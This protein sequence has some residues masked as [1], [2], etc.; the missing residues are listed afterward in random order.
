MGDPG[1]REKGSEG[2][3]AAASG[4]SQ[5][6]EHTQ[7]L[8]NE[9]LKVNGVTPVIGASPFVHHG[10]APGNAVEAFVSSA[11]ASLVAPVEAAG[12]LLDRAAGTHTAEAL[13]KVAGT[14]GQADFGSL[15]WAASQLGT[16]AG[17]T[18]W[19]FGL[20]RGISGSVRSLAGVEELSVAQRIG[21]SAASGF[22]YGTGL[23]PTGSG[24]NDWI[25]HRLENGVVSALSFTALTGSSE[26]LGTRGITNKAVSGFLAGAP[27][28][29]V[30]T[31]AR[32]LWNDGKF[33]FDQELGQS[34]ATYAFL[35]GALGALP[36]FG[37]SEPKSE[38]KSGPTQSNPNDANAT[39]PRS[40]AKATP[41]IT[42]PPDM[43]RSPDITRPPDNTMQPNATAQ[44]TDANAQRTEPTAQRLEATAPRTDAT[45]PRTEAAAQSESPA[46]VKKS[47]DDQLVKA[48]EKV[49][50]TGYFVAEES[51]Q[52]IRDGLT[53]N[54]APVPL[55]WSAPAEMHVTEEFAVK[56]GAGNA[57]AK[58]PASGQNIRVI[59]YALDNTGVESLVVSVDG[60]TQRSDGKYYHLT[61]SL[62]EGR[63][64]NESMSVVEKAMAVEKARAEG[65]LAEI[66]PEV[67]QRYSY[68][69][70]SP[71]EQ[72]NLSVDARF[73]ESATTPKAEKTKTAK[74]EPSFDSLT[75]RLQVLSALKATPADYLSQTIQTRTPEHRAGSYF[76]MTPQQ[77]KQ[78][79]F[80]AKWEPYNPLDAEGHPLISGGARGYR[81]TIPGGRLGMV[82]VEQLP[83]GANL[84]LIDPKG[85]GKWSLSTI[86]TAE[87]KTDTATMIVGP[88]EAGKHSLW[89]FHPGE[90]VRT[91]L[92]DSSTLQNALGNSGIKTEGL[93]E[94]GM[95]RRIAITAEQLNQIN[96]ALPDK[97]KFGL[98][99]IESA[100]NL[101]KP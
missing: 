15:T 26:F 33:K 59:G 58:A 10:P 3:A 45:V 78:E 7:L 65:R 92:L 66:P 38:A 93:P 87:P 83:A 62:A 82:P 32:S 9:T 75:P 56:E 89:T 79:L 95:G 64:A 70:L 48:K 19:L 55:R 73:K 47:G 28:G 57:W 23:T 74:P 68:T 91:S 84:Y 98:A 13:A 21:V 20:H 35:G 72:F 6:Q 69:A 63:R 88:D 76:D 51:G 24:D 71:A 49:G 80:S 37:K 17:M 44:R 42:R 4:A 86:G 29:F 60:Q 8:L 100:D 40:D 30:D 67:A 1:K 22:V 12:E 77:L 36:T 31:E 61:R 11:R 2:N 90:P 18:P 85:T 14:P 81:A 39:T 53:V 43:T 5:G 16:A 52:R 34:M 97:A 46:D 96:A 41:D 27:A 50:Y 101:P 25:K 54:G 99:K 94:N